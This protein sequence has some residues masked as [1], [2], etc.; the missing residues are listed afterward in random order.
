M[1]VFIYVFVHLRVL[2][3]HHRLRQFEL[4]CLH[5]PCFSMLQVRKPRNEYNDS[6]NSQ[7]QFTGRLLASTET[8]LQ[9]PV[10]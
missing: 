10:S 8:D 7:I 1:Y 6:V 9:S 5:I 3:S 4:C 2:A